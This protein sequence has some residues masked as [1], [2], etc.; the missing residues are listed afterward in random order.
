MLSVGE[1]GNDFIDG[2]IKAMR[3]HNIPMDVFGSDEAKMKYPMISYPTDF[4]YVLDHSGGILRADKALK[5]FQVNCFV[6]KHAHFPFTIKHQSKHT[7]CSGKIS[8]SLTV[9]SKN[10]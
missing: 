3:K 7:R 5:A 10:C 6:P 8:A 4:T 2:T 9:R 1:P